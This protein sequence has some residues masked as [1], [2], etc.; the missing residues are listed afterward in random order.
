MEA[1]RLDK[2][3]TIQAFTTT[4]NSIGEAVK[5]WA[6]V[7]TVW[8]AVEPLQGREFWSQQQVQSEV[9]TRVR[10]RFRTDVTAKNR[11]LFGGRVLVV[12]SVINPKERKEE[13][14]L[15]CSEGVSNG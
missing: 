1:G 14:Q 13:L 4:P 7:A 12:E 10:I 5:G 6:N 2:Q 11:V 15:M 8:A 9:T 3:V